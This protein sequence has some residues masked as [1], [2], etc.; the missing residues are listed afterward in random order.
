MKNL[1]SI[2]AFVLLTGCCT[3]VEDGKTYRVQRTE[4]SILNN[5]PYLLDI[6]QDGSL[7]RSN[8]RTGLVFP[9]PPRLFQGVSILTVTG[10]TDAGI[11]V[12][13]SRWIFYWNSPDTW[14]V[15]GLDE[16][17]PPTR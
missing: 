4:H 7:V 17:A 8:L 3:V 10:H 9:V 1:I 15:N 16:A 2:L 13:A 12:G 5:T 6:F 11:Y 14:I